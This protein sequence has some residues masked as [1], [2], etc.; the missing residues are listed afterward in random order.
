MKL[1]VVS[2]VVL[3]SL[4]PASSHEP[5]GLVQYLQDVGQKAYLRPYLSDDKPVAYVRT[6]PEPNIENETGTKIVYI[7]NLPAHP[8]SEGRRRDY[9][10]VSSFVTNQNG[11]TSGGVQG[12]IN[13]QMFSYP[14]NQKPGQKPVNFV[15][16]RFGEE[17]QN[18]K[19]SQGDF[20]NGFNFPSAPF[21]YPPYGAFPFGFSA[22]P[23]YGAVPFGYPP[24]FAGYPGFSPFPFYPGSSFPAFEPNQQNTMQQFRPNPSEN[25]RFPKP[26]HE[27]VE[28][29]VDSTEQ[30]PV[31]QATAEPTTDAEKAKRS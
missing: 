1:K 10:S 31:T 6:F 30:K 11:M 9:Q 14:L 21:G 18:Q 7:K 28:E 2:L 22:F 13:G 26:T 3:L 29:R 16:N 5:D 15:P 25:M 8:N 27:L 17:N 4:S 19:P 23:Q 20:F 12:N 24:V